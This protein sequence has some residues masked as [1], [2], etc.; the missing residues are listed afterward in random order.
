MPCL[1][2]VLNPKVGISVQLKSL[3]SAQLPLCKEEETE[4][5][6]MS[7]EGILACM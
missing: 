6:G 5:Q 3:L 2:G 4:V 7:Q 1:Q